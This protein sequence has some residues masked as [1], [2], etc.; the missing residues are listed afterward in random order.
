MAYNIK[1]SKELASLINYTNLNNIITESEMKEFLNKAKEMNF[2]SV[3]VSP[4]YVSL[5]KEILEGTDIKVGSVIGFPLGFEDTE[6]KIA[7]AKSLNEKGVDE[8][9]VVLNISYLKDEKYD[10]LENEIRQIKEVIGDKILKVVIETKAL[11]DYEKANAA[12]VAE[13]SGADYVKTATGFVSPNHIFENVNDINIIQKYA[14]K[15]KIEIFGGIT[16][17]KFANQIL[18]GGADIIGSDQGYEIVKRYKDL[19]ENTQVT[20][21]PITL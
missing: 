16:N 3:V 6:S 4:T 17:Y 21:K 10:L 18:T 12:K 7:S 20:P 2:N 15:I 11:E 1:N 5:A 14:P 19:R 8:F 9:E 13:N